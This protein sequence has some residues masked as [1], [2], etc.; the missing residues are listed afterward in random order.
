MVVIYHLAIYFISVKNSPY[1]I[2]PQYACPGKNKGYNYILLNSYRD[3]HCRVDYKLN[4][5][6]HNQ[7]G[8]GTCQALNQG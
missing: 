5:E 8:Q 4:N 6:A 2:S 1:H 3:V 7:P